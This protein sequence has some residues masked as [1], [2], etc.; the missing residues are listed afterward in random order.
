MPPDLTVDEE[1]VRWRPGFFTGRL[2]ATFPQPNLPWRFR[3][4]SIVWALC[5]AP[6]AAIDTTE[7][8]DLCAT[9]I[10][11]INRSTRGE[12]R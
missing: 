11:L 3:S 2:H 8:S 7:G 4:M 10:D 12:R 9:C 1:F 5:G 6:A